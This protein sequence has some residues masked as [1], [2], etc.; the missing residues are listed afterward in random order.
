MKK[1]FLILLMISCVL[2]VKDGKAINFPADFVLDNLPQF[3]KDMK[4]T[5]VLILAT[6]EKRIM[7]T[8]FLTINEKKDVLVVTNKH[9]IPAGMP[10]FVRVNAPG[11][12]IDYLTEPYKA[13]DITHRR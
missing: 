11:G 5:T 1:V 13:V 10:V 7:G 3:I 12:V 2:G 6:D 4:R 8:G 9:Q